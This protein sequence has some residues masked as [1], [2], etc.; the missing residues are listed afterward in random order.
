MTGKGIQRG[1]AR[2][3]GHRFRREGE[4]WTMT[5]RGTTARLRH[6]KGMQHLALLMAQPGSTVAATELSRCVDHGVA[7]PATAIHREGELAE[8][9]ART[10]HRENARLRVRRA[11]IGA[12]T[13]I[14]QHHP[15]L[16][17][18]LKATIRLG[19]RCAYQPDPHAYIHWE[20]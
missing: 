1:G 11:I 9:A 10:L 4:Y 15:V 18:H 14:A 12:L 8:R 2:R 3:R 13:R 6:S 7:L 16:A 20:L 5:Y 17:A 19:D